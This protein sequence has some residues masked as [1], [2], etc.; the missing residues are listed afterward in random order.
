METGSE[1]FFF[2]GHL[3]KVKRLEWN[4]WV[5]ERKK[6]KQKRIGP[7]LVKGIGKR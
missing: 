5:Q 7:I 1:S 2:P 4:C 3:A 6:I